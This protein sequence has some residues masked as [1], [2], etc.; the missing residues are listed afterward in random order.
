MGAQNMTKKFG[1]LPSGKFCHLYTISCGGIEAKIADI[2]ATLVSL[3]LPDRNGRSA[4]VVLG[5]DSG[6]EYIQNDGCLGAVVGR[7]ANR[8]GG[9]R[10]C[11]KGREVCLNANEGGNSLH[12]GP[13][14]WF[15]RLWR[16]E[17][18][19]KDRI[20]LCLTTPDA[21][22]G[23]PGSGEVRVTYLLEK[24]SLTVRYEGTFDQDTLFNP[25][26]H[27][28]F[29]LAGQDQGERAMDQVLW[30]RASR[31]T[32]VDHRAIPTGRILEVAGTALDFRH[33]RI[34]GRGWKKDP[35][36]GPL[37][38]IDHNLILDPAE[39]DAPAARLR[40]PGSGRTMTVYTDCPG[41]QVYCANYLNVMG[42]GGVRYGPN[43]GLCLETQFFPD[44]P[45]H[46]HWPQ[47]TVQAGTTATRT[48]R[49]LFGAE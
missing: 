49:F 24:N 14:Y 30:V 5:Y 34:L 47:C 33:P 43:S 25:T 2:G 1:V 45:N 26:Q 17:S 41:L 22:Q 15:F 31:F 3:Q 37:G 27:A 44:S 10:F 29:N 6:G 28:Y 48:T 12:S 4:D 9:A 13:D 23:F 32:E 39:K 8:I 35:L 21:D 20:T 46:P 38:G 11:L 19:G 36:V 7:Y 42:K 16:V 18:H 40:D